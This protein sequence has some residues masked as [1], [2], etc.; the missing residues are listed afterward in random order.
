MQTLTRTEKLRMLYEMIRVRECE[1]KIF[2]LFQ[3]GTMFG[4]GHMS[5][6]Q[7][8]C[9]VGAL[10]ALGESDY[11]ATH[12]RG[13]GHAIVRGTSVERLFAELLGKENGTNKGMGGS[14]HICDTSVNSVGSHGILGENFGVAAGV[15]F[16]QK[17]ESTDNICA[18]F[19]GDGSSNAGTFHEIM[20]IAMLWKLPLLL[21]CENNQYAISTSYARSVCTPTISERAKAYGAQ[22]VT[23][24]GNDV[25]A[26]YETVKAA[27]EKA[28]QGIPSI[29]EL[30]TY[31]WFGHSLRVS[32]KG[33]RSEEEENA[34][35]AKCPI[36][37][38][39]SHLLSNEDCSQSD[40]D[41]M[42]QK[43]RHEI[44]SSLENALKGESLTYAQAKSMIFA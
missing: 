42:Y 14:I 1:N 41:D 16:A 17:Y 24:D 31:R 32:G 8:A 2:E 11:I 39:S 13:H 34:W 5:V 9:A 26:V 27:A 37:K 10:A 25:L 36:L 6:G 33:Y 21:I 29:V 7:E 19:F 43:A 38:L 44:E 40:I 18:C 12:H 30:V 15:A 23:I 4:L 35:K 22:G 20:N 28:R 3:K